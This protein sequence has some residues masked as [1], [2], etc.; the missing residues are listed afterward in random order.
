[1]THDTTPDLVPG[2]GAFIIRPEHLR[3]IDESDVVDGAGARQGTAGSVSDVSYLGS[4]TRYVVRLD[5]GA[6][7][8]VAEL[9]GAR[10]AAE[11]LLR[12]DA[13]VRVDWDERHLVPLPDR[14]HLI[15]SATGG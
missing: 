3:L 11:A 4:E 6:V 1:M 9:N 14:S 10:T 13:R 7:L 2:S 5:A 15:A 12:R 8:T